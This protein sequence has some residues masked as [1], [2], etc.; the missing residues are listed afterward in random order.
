MRPRLCWFLVSFFIGGAFGLWLSFA[1]PATARPGSSTY[2]EVAHLMGVGGGL[3]VAALI[4]ATKRVTHY[5]WA[6]RLATG[7]AAAAPPAHT[8]GGVHR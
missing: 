8:P 6:V 1:A 4:G 5:R 2:G 3:W 7:T